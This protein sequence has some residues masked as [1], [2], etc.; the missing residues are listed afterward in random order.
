[1]DLA[2]LTIW[3]NALLSLGAY[4]LSQWVA[5]VLV[6]PWGFVSGNISYFDG[7]A[8]LLMAFV[9]YV[10]Y[11]AGGAFAGAL[12]AL[13]TTGQNRWQWSL[14]PAAIAL[15]LFPLGRTRFGDLSLFSELVL[16][17]APGI[18]IAAVTVGC[19]YWVSRWSGTNPNS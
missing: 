14:V 8:V 17:F 16:R 15:A 18:Y 10:P 3:R 13:L 7:A 2:N 9:T 12:I 19:A 1:V 5:V 6:W 4:H 11:I